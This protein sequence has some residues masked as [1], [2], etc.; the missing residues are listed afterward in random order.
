MSRSPDSLTE[1]SADPL[2]RLLREARVTGSIFSRAELRGSWGLHTR[3]TEHALFH[4]VVAGGG[5]VE[6]DG[7]TEAFS[8]GDVLLFPRGHAHAL[9]DS[10]GRETTWI[11]S[12]ARIPGGVP[13]VEA[14]TPGSRT[15]L[16]CGSFRVGPPLDRIFAIG[17]PPLVRVSLAA[18][19]GW[20]DGTG[21]W[22]AE[23]VDASQS[24]GHV[25]VDR[26]LEVLLVEVIRAWAGNVPGILAPLFDP[27]LAPA[28]G[29]VISDPAR[30]W[31]TG[32]L[33][34]RAG[35]SR[36]AFFERFQ[37][38]A[39]EPPGR[40][41]TRYRLTVGFGALRGGE[42]VSTAAERAGYTSHEG[43]SRAFRREF[44]VPPSE[45]RAVA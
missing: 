5:E 22:L 29:A 20:L 28:I 14:G 26:L 6:C 41:V 31:S 7:R 1:R 2:G 39:T 37:A 38:V 4:V 44:G 23:T 10:P 34:R 11:G 25:V 45:W 18:T 16:L 21:R 30:S 13:T 24:E 3:G 12:L 19:A 36:T 33:A 43:F 27:V 8:H 35:V 15:A 32:T 40:W 42:P 9:R 17:L